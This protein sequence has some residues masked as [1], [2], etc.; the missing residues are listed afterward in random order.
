MKKLLLFVLCTPFL[1]A[2]TCESSD[3]QNE[4]IYCTQEFVDGLRITVVD[5]TNGQALTDGVE[6]KAAD[7]A[8]LETLELRPME[9][10][11]AGAGER[12]GTYIVT[13]TKAGYQTYT[14]S[15][16][17]ATRDYCHVITQKLTVNLNPN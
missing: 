16:I 13:V 5:A 3:D 6:V 10:L 1:L 4:P 11:F 12:A 17:V 2:S 8:Y 14:S 7:G 9:Q 15:P